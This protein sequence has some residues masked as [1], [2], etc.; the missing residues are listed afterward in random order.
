MA[1]PGMTSLE[2]MTPAPFGLFSAWADLPPAERGNDYRELKRKL[3]DELLTQLD[4]RLPGVIGHLEVVDMS[5][6]LSMASWVGAVD[7]GLYGPAQTPGQSVP[8]RFSTSTHLPNLFL[9][10]AGVYGG[11]ILPCLESGRAAAH[12]AASVAERTQTRR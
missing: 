2:V 3:Q 7:G 12:R 1:P 5:T 10:G 11:G 6:P 9:A 8:F 4:Q